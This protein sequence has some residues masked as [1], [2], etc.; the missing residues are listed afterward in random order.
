LSNRFCSGESNIKNFHLF[1]AISVACM[2]GFNF[3]IIKLGVSEM[4]PLI[5]TGLRFT[6][7]TFPAIFFIKKPK[8]S[9]FIL[10]LYGIT[11]GVGVWGMLT[12]SI[13]LGLSAGMSSLILQSSA[14]IS[15]LFGIFFLK[16]KLS[17]T[18]K[19]GLLVSILGLALIFT[20]E[21]GSVTLIGILFACFAAISLSIISLIIKKIVIEDMFGF[22]V[23]SCA[24]AP[25]PL[26]SLSLMINGVSGFDMLI[27]NINYLSAFSVLFQAYPVTVLGYWLWNK[28]VAQY[29]M[30]TMA[31]LTLLVPIFGLLGSVIF[32]NEQIGT[33]KLLASFLILFGIAIGLS[34]TLIPKIKCR[35]IERE[36]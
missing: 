26:F 13:Q 27:R 36:R 32:Y 33:T 30:S 14:F 15:V 35:I 5:L 1:I 18:R 19:T 29:P 28:L 34:E 24:F 2:W 22:V 31:P 11:F 4:D 3:S 21:D 6:F 7:A 12:L 8:V 10:A 9:L 25:I 23:W 20:I 17:I 16:E